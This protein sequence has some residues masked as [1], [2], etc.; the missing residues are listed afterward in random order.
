[1]INQNTN[2]AINLSTFLISVKYICLIN[3][4]VRPYVKNHKCSVAHLKIIN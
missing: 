2:L 3:I 4:Q 1:M